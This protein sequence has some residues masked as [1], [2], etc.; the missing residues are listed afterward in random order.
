MAKL[1]VGIGEEFPM[2]DSAGPD[3]EALRR[4]REWARRKQAFRDF[5][6]KVKIAARESFGEDWDHYVG[7]FS[8]WSLFGVLLV[9]SG[10]L[11][12]VFLASAV[13]AA[14]LK[15]APV[16]LA[17]GVL[18]AIVFWFYRKRHGPAGDPPRPEVIVTP[19]PAQP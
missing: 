14:I 4:Q 2:D 5:W 18:F 13:I 11:F 12:V 6:N 8:T 10:A 16:L 19:P 7:R 15:A 3:E 1:G 9:G 17:T